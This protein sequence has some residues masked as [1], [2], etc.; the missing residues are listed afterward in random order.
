MSSWG[1]SGLHTVNNSYDDG[2]AAAN[3]VRRD[4]AACNIRSWWDIA[5]MEDDMAKAPPPPASVSS[6]AA[7]P[8]QPSVG[9]MG[10]RASHGKVS[11]GDY[12]YARGRWCYQ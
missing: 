1:S 7:A 4:V 3:A 10:T 6:G 5:A 2:G 9:A 8:A 11:C 12:K